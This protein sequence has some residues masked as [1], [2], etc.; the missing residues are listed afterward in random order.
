MEKLEADVVIVGCGPAGIFTALELAE[1]SNLKLV[2]VDRGPDIEERHCLARGGSGCVNCN[3]C[4]M[5]CGWGGAGA[6]SDGKLTLSAD[7]GGWLE[8]YIGRE[9]LISLI[10]YVDKMYLAF[11]APQMLFGT[12]SDVI[13]SLKRSA[14]MAGLNLI[15]VKVRHV[16]T[17]RCFEVIK[18][19]RDFLSRRVKILTERAVASVLVDGSSARGVKLA[20]GTKIDAKYVVLAPGRSGAE[21][22][23][24]LT[25]EL[26]FKTYNN[27]V[28]IGVRV[29]VPA[30]VME[31]L[32]KYLYEPKL[33]YY[34]KSFD[35]QVRT[36]CFNPYGEV[37]TESYDGVVT[38]NGH[39]FLNKKTGNTNFAVLVSTSFTEP[40]KEPIAYGKYIARLA[41]LL[42]GGI[43]VQRLGDLEEG[44]RSTPERIKRNIVEPTLRSAT[45][46]DLS[47]VLPY[48]YLQNIL[49]MLQALDKLAPGV[50]SRYTLLYGVEV[51]FY[52]S[53]LELSKN[54]E[55]KVENLYAA[56]DGAGITRGLIQA[57]ASGIVVAR[58]ILQ[59]EG[60][61]VSGS[62]NE[63]NL[64]MK[65]P[66]RL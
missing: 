53:R 39:S 18:A 33:L 7:V 27:P 36:F 10:D 8:E 21:W 64:P 37:I 25:S 15:P 32:T 14:Q 44:R 12:E 40:F 13:E 28:D 31:P 62:A 26:K 11:G 35:D 59:K 51:K 42:S 57:S 58:S 22:L 41:N 29:E 20:D 66:S 3:P 60:Y 23:K 5:L 16:G 30:P 1:R 56:G 50:Y 49:E 52:S 34:S 45:P 46:G 55:T 2:M 38:V 4:A 24:K 43:I 65:V 63:E 19:M 47:F 54:L 17:E 6:F 9:Q 61:A 48:R